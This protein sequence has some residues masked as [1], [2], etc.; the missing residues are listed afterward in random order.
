MQCETDN[1]NNNNE[2]IF[3][4]TTAMN[5]VDSCNIC[6]YLQKPDGSVEGNP[7][8]GEEV[9]GSEIRQQCPPYA[10]AACFDAASY[11]K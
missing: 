5:K 4:K 10:D 8:C 3:K 6:S 9:T 2:A 11:H 7:S 1:C